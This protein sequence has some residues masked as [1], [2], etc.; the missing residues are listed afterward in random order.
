MKEREREGGIERMSEG[1]MGEGERERTRGERELEGLAT[2]GPQS[3]GGGGGL[4]RG[5]ANRGRRGRA[6]GEVERGV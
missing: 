6:V 5:E 2:K 4:E 1:E 3:W